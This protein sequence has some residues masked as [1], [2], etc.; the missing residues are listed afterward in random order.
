ML[1]RGHI[2]RRAIYWEGMG[3]HPLYK[4]KF[5]LRQKLVHTK[6]AEM[7]CKSHIGVAGDG[8]TKPNHLQNYKCFSEMHYTRLSFPP[9]VKLLA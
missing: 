6:T 2:F 1:M 5:V 9:V 8:E 4:H 7:P 3:G